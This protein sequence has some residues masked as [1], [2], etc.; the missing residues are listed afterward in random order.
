MSPLLTTINLARLITRW[1]RWKI[2]P[3][4]ASPEWPDADGEGFVLETDNM[5]GDPSEFNTRMIKPHLYHKLLLRV[6]T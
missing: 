2:W 3:I 4:G 6:V 5:Y 1:L